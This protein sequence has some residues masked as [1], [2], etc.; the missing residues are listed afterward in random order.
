MTRR[1]C[2]WIS[3]PHCQACKKQ[4]VDLI[5]GKEKCGEGD[6]LGIS[7]GIVRLLDRANHAIVAIATMSTNFNSKR[8]PDLK[9]RE[10]ERPSKHK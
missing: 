6:D 2:W 1:E 10:E 9:P 3:A 4:V 8:Q 5:S 7:F